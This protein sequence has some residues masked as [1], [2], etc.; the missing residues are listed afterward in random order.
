M[1]KLVLIVLLI[2]FASTA[3]NLPKLY[4]KVNSSVVFIDIESY[5]YSEV[6][7]SQKVN[8][9]ESL[10]SG[11]LVG[12]EGLIW[13]AAHVIQSAE[14]ITVEFTDGDKYEA[15][16]IASDT[17]ADV[18]LIKVK[19]G[20]QLKKKDVAVIA[21]SDKANIGDNVFIIGAPHGFKQSLSR[22]IISGRFVPEGLSSSFEKVEF[23]QTDASINPGNS[24]GPMFNMDGE[25]I[26]IASRIYTTSGG[27]DGIGFAVASN[28]AKKLLSDVS[29]SWS[30]MESL[31]LTPELAALLNVPQKAGVLVTKISSKGTAAKLGLIGGYIP[32]NVAGQEVLLGGD[33]ILEIAGVRLENQES[34]YHIK[35][36]L[37]HIKKGTKVSIVILRHG[38][39]M[40]TQFEK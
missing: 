8:T 19:E 13:T 11:V 32:I 3:Q 39:Q 26:G 20:F 12:K 17:N 36:K 33:I 16:V 27:F 22:G 35:D 40:A 34:I 31:F 29:G 24:G 5:D 1:K 7:F 6:L 2:S 38:Q 9:E 21:D 18:A 37:K 30:G 25:V 28:V 4:N 15:E 23:L 14:K 10:G